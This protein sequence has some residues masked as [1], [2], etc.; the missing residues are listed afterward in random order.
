M[1]AENKNGINKASTA[2][3]DVL[4][5]E[6]SAWEAY[7]TNQGEK[8]FRGQQV[9]QR[10][11][12]SSLKDIDDCTKDLPTHLREQICND[13]SIEEPRFKS[14]DTASDGVHKL[15]I[16]VGNNSLIESVIIPEK[17]RTTLCIS[18]QVGCA[19]A[20]SFCLT[21]VQGF[22]RNLTTAEII[23][24]LR[25][26]NRF[27]A[28]QAEQRQIS[29][30]VMMGM[31]EPLLNSDAV[32]PALRMMIDQ[33]GYALSPRR[34]TISTSGIVPAIFKL[35]EACNVA[36]AVSL[37]APTNAIRDEIMPINKKYPLASLMDACR[38]YLQDKPRHFITFEYVMIDGI[39]DHI[40]QARALIKLMHK[41]RCKINLIPFNPF[42]QVSYRTSPLDR[43]HQFRD[44][45]M[46]AGLMTTIRKTRGD[47]I[48]AA[49]GQLAGEIQTDKT[50]GLGKKRVPIVAV[51]S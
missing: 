12:K 22:L 27:L 4:G 48:L 20:C 46:K 19:L 3:P 51:N 49:C 8:P 38:A 14:V 31:G 32:F 50:R 21:G 26:S 1:T 25:I 30:V 6:R 36:L 37:H 43:I 44:T 11:H 2:L 35:R 18:S 39:N 33:H 28:T 13:Y 34:V 45:L 15:L 17:N 7:F 24:Q 40:D 5:A 10:L 41:M 29:N 42:P 9:F 23:A 47:N 16:D